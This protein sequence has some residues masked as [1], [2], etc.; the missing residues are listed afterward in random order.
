MASTPGVSISY[1]HPDPSIFLVLQSPTDS[2][3]QN[4]LDRLLD[5]EEAPHTMQRGGRKAHRLVIDEL[6]E[7]AAPDEHAVP[8]SG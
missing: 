8:T 4:L 7:D 6:G 5:H 3:A 2:A 1:D